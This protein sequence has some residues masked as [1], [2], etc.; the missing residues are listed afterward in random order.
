MRDLEFEERSGAQPLAVLGD[1]NALRRVVDILLDNAF[2]YTPSPGK[3]TL[4]AEEKDGSAVVSVAD[5]GIG[6]APE[7]RARI[8]E[9]FYRV[10]KAR[11]RSVGGA[12]LGLAIAQWI[13]Q[14]HKGKLEVESEPGN[15]SVFQLEL[16]LATPVIAKRPE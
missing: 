10:D 1:E 16:P 11:S 4:S 3:V 2:K 6:I 13:V 8:F 9:R 14:L 15:G 7:D 5:T 12:G